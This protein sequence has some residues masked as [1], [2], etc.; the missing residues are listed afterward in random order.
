MKDVDICKDRDLPLDIEKTRKRRR[1][2]KAIRRKKLKKNRKMVK[3]KVH[4]NT[5]S[6]NRKLEEEKNK[7]LFGHNHLKISDLIQGNLNDCS[8]IASLAS[9]LNFKYGNK[10][11]REAIPFYNEVKYI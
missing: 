6:T 7:K 8:F 5:N 9:I 10:Y 1:K 11:I 3:E 4:K 2:R